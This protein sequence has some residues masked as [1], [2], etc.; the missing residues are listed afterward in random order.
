MN[1]GSIK[2]QA[3]TTTTEESDSPFIEGDSEIMSTFTKPD[4]AIEDAWNSLTMAQT[5]DLEKRKGI[6]SLQDFESAI[7]DM[8]TGGM[9][10]EEA[11]EDIKE[12]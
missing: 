2:S 4:K 5:K 1:R 3:S 9:T 8:V 6:K 11:L 7:T 10:Q 12:C